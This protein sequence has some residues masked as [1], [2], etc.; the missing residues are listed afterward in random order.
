MAP[1]GRNHQAVAPVQFALNPL[2]GK[3]KAGTALQQTQPFSLGLVI[4]K[5]R[6]AA[7]RAGMQ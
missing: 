4:P 7:S 1:V 5:A 6:R 3:L 2:I